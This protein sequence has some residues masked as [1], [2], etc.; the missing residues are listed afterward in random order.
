MRSLMQSAGR[1]IAPGDLTA[2]ISFEVET[3]T[4]DG[5]GG[6]TRSWGQAFEAWAAVEPLFV[7]EREEIG[8]LR[9]VVQYRFTI[10]RTSAV[11]E[12]MRIRY[13][14]QTHAIKGFRL[15]G[16]SELFMQIITE[17]GLGD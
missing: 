14:G 12:Q 8:A 7:G 13:A 3:R 17:T 15:S 6:A 11:T 4:G 9:N 2:R 1:R 10:Y 5:Y 16:P